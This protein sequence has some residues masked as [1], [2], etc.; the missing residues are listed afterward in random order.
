MSFSQ[1]NEIFGE[2]ILRNITRLSSDSLQFDIVLKRTTNDWKYF[3]NSIFQ[4][5]FDTN[6]FKYDIN[7]IGISRIVSSLTPGV[8]IGNNNPVGG[9]TMIELIQDN[10]IL[11]AVLG[12]ETIEE[13]NQLIID[14]EFLLG[15]YNLFTKDK[16]WIPSNIHWV[17]PTEYNQAVAYKVEEDKIFDFITLYHKNDNIDLNTR[18]NQNILFTST[19]LPYAYSILLEYFRVEYLSQKNLAI[20]WKT[21]QELNVVGFTIKKALKESFTDDPS[22]LSYDVIYTW[23]KDTTNKFD[24]EMFSKGN[25]MVG[26]LYG[27][28][29]DSVEIR[30]KEYCYQLFCNFYDSLKKPIMDDF[31][32]AQVCVPIPKAIIIQA[33]LLSSNPFTDEIQIEFKLSDDCHM[34]VAV[35][36]LL[37]K[38]VEKVPLPGAT[39]EIY[40]KKY[41]KKGIHQIK[42]KPNPSVSSGSYYVH[43]LAYPIDDNTVE[44]SKAVIKIMNQR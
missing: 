5:S 41:T 14:D 37:G 18:D 12:P 42:F 23:K 7:K 4:I 1:S 8:Q 40:D 28:L 20:D 44:I 26:H 38:E 27:V 2:A 35:Y 6:T 9:Y 24:P 19:Y 31:F 39:D 43:L 16:S 30:G 15:K 22:T 21:L 25:T 29:P 34:T 11:I 32:L 36:D 3:A 17:I 13:S 33:E 10:N